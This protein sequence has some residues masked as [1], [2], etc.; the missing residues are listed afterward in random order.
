[1]HLGRVRIVCPRACA[2]ASLLPFLQS[3]PLLCGR[4]VAVQQLRHLGGN[5]G[6][7]GGIEGSAGPGLGAEA[8]SAPGA[9]YR[10]LPVRYACQLSYTDFVREFMAPNR[11]VVLRVRGNEVER[12]VALSPMGPC[13]FNSYLQ[14]WHSAGSKFAVPWYRAPAILVS[15][16]QLAQAS[17]ALSKSSLPCPSD[18]R[19]HLTAQL[20][21][22]HTIAT[23][24]GAFCTCKI[25]RVRTWL[26]APHCHPFTTMP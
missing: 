23:A 17:S 13:M 12:P 14:P 22:W 21:R 5:G 9:S 16:L 8:S 7:M 3:D 19:P 20:K 18:H 6:C 26:F 4:E 10:Q 24:R 2:T 11:P 15:Q 1:M 25:D